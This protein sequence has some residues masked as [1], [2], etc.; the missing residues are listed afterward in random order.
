MFNYKN[1]LGSV[2]FS[3]ED[4]VFHG[5]IEFIRPLVSFEGTDVDGLEAAFREAVD[6]YLA[7]CQELGKVPEKAFK[8]TFNV[9]TGSRL[10]RHA[11]LF[12]KQNGTNLNNV[13]ID[14]LNNY[15][16]IEQQ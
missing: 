7:L 11:A 2:H 1:Y 8:G 3:E 12:A 13:V 15:L 4:R 5:K 14:A 6:D 10:H 16:P 9:R